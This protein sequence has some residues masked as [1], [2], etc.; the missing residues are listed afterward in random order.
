[1]TGYP[2]RPGQHVCPIRPCT[3]QVADRLL[4]C[5]P[6]W[7]KVPVPVQ[8]DVYAAY[9][10]GAGLGTDELLAAQVAA[11]RSVY[12]ALGLAEEV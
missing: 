12:R 9:R 2:R 11:I 3:T 8:R 1:M 5:G 10:G 4:M 6:H 7:A